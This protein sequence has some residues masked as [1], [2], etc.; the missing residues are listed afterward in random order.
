MSPYDD[1]DVVRLVRTLRDIGTLLPEQRYEEGSGQAEP[2]QRVGVRRRWLI[3]VKGGKPW[4][5][6]R[7]VLRALTVL[8]FR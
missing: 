1:F 6:I 8:T 7:P 3:E 2:A 4:D 5:E